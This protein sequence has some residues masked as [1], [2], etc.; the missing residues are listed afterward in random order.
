MMAL[1]AS[2]P[3]I[4]DIFGATGFDIVETS[5]S[6][7]TTPPDAARQVQLIPHYD[8]TDPHQL[9]IMHHLHHLP[10]TG[11][12]FYRHIRTGIECVNTAN[13]TDFKQGKAEDDAELGPIPPLYTGETNARFENLLQVDGRFN[14]VLIY[15]GCLLHAGIIPQGFVYDSDPHKGRLTGNMFVRIRK[16]E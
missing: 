13:T 5:F 6:I 15:Q 1:K 10:D 2:V 12:A 7:V 16:P 8:S 11:T 14:R 3:Y 9:A 4:R